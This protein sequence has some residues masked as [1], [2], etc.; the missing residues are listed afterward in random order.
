MVIL[1]LYPGN[2][3]L[4][5][6]DPGSSWVSVVNSGDLGFTNDSF[7]NEAFIIEDSEFINAFNSL[8]WI[9]ISVADVVSTDDIP[10]GNIDVITIEQGEATS[11][12][13]NSGWDYRVEGQEV[14]QSSVGTDGTTV[15]VTHPFPF[16]GLEVYGADADI[17]NVE[18]GDYWSNYF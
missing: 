10:F 16:T 8:Y 1:H 15:T 7:T 9:S 5:I 3:L 6:E 11:D 18:L 17:T 4:G 14:L 13:N 12:I 2:Q